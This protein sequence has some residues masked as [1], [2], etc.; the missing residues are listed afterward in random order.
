MSHDIL[1]LG[2]S[3]G[4]LLGTKLA[5]AGH[6][7]TLVCTQSTARLI[8]REGTRVRFPIRGRDTPLEIRSMHLPGSTLACTPDEVDPSAYDMIALGMQESQYGN[9][10]V[11]PLVQQ[12]A[13]SGRPCMAIMNMPP[14][15][16]LHRLDRLS[17]LGLRRCYAEASLWDDFDPALMTLASPDPQAF[18][19]PEEPK[20][21]LQVGLPTNFKVARFESEQHTALLREIAC[22]I[23]EARYTCEGVAIDVPVRLK[24]HDSKFVPLAK[25]PMLITGNYRCI[26]AQGAISIRDAV[27]SDPAAS[28]RI[29][30]WVAEL[31]MSIGAS[32]E[33]LVPFDKYA[34]AARDLGKP[35][36]V[37]RALVGGAKHVERVD[38]LVERIAVQRGG[39]LPELR[40]IVDR[41][42]GW[43]ARNRTPVN[44][45]AGLEL[46]R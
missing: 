36:S 22:S 40:T 21:V 30:R 13:A 41:V 15:A 4:S 3:Y 6:R 24:V 25:W 26:Q 45:D 10:D 8:N 23:D 46:V 20:N 33:D 16:Y 35:A 32:A 34:K 42:D 1:I 9:P 43:L 11:L 44:T 29:Y 37:A 14:L 12:V 39:S 2:A 7:V 38:A 19:P 27:W 5:M 17:P 18:R 31:C 28:E